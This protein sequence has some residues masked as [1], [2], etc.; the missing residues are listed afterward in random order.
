[1][2]KKCMEPMGRA[3]LSLMAWN[4]L[5]PVEV[6]RLNVKDVK[7]KEQSLTVWGKGRSLKHKQVIPIFKVPRKELKG[8]LE[9]TRG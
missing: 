8:L 4:G 7:L 5:R 2:M 6:I 3:I 1:M 9:A